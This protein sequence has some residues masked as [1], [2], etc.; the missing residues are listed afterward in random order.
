MNVRALERGMALAR[1][2][3]ERDLALAHR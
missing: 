1:E 2:L 3:A